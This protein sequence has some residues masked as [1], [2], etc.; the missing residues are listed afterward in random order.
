MTSSFGELYDHVSDL[1]VYLLLCHTIGVVRHPWR[2]VPNVGN[3]L[4][5]APRAAHPGRCLPPPLGGEF[6][7]AGTMHR[8]RESL[9]ARAFNNAMHKQT[10]QRNPGFERGVGDGTRRRT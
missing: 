5:T 1:V 10:V 7:R 8:C 9:H 6:Y 4:P 2:T 3:T